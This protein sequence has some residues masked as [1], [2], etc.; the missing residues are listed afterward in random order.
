MGQ[1]EAKDRSASLVL[2]HVC[3]TRGKASC[4]LPVPILGGDGETGLE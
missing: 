1:I 3:S 4:L 2:A